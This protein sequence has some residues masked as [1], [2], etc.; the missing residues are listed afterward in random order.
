MTRMNLRAAGLVLAAVFGVGC[1]S[2]GN[3]QMADTLGKGHVQ[4]GIEPGMQ[5]LAAMG[6][7]A[8]TQPI[9]YPHFDASVRFGVTEGIDLG[10]RGG[11]SFLEAQGKFLFTRPGDPHLAVSLAPT[12]GGMAIGLGGSSGAAL[13]LIN[14]GLPVLVGIKVPGGSEFVIGPRLQNLVAFAGASGAGGT[15]YFLSGGGSLGFAWRITDTFAL[16]PEAAVV[17]PIF[18]SGGTSS[19]FGAQPGLGTFVFQFK[20]GLLIGR[21]RDLAQPEDFEVKQVANPQLPPPPPPPPPEENVPPPPP[22]PSP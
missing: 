4:V 21:M 15:L 9:Y 7:G 20:V 3:V 8:G 14:I 10:V 1:A 19:A 18:G 17:F 22:P 11:W 5:A 12:V 6:A 2:I 13:G 16:M